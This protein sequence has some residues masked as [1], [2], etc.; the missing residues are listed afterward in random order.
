MISSF[1]SGKQAIA[2]QYHAISLELMTAWAGH[3]AWSDQLVS[4]LVLSTKK[5]TIHPTGPFVDL[6]KNL[7]A[8]I[9]RLDPE[10]ASFERFTCITQYIAVI[11]L[12]YV[13][14][15]HRSSFFRSL[16]TDASEFMYQ[17]QPKTRAEFECFV[18]N[19]MFVINSWKTE[20]K[21]E[22]G[23]LHLLRSMKQRFPEMRR[24]ESILDIVQRFLVMPPYIAE[25]KNDWLQSS[26]S[27][28]DDITNEA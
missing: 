28:A 26:S 23:G 4:S 16:R 19:S 1:P 2:Y 11:R 20:A 7:W 22:E 10:R 9:E 6:L 15:V 17:F 5:H 3:G 13:A 18:Y 27:N 21:L 14:I 25:W 12:T 8:I 24:W